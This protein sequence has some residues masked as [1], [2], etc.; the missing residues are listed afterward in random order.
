[1][2]FR[3]NLTL[4][5]TKMAGDM[6]LNRIAVHE[7]SR[8]KNQPLLVRL[9]SLDFCIIPDESGQFLVILPDD[10]SDKF[11]EIVDIDEYKIRT[12]EDIFDRLDYFDYKN[13]SITYSTFTYRFGE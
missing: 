10:L 7:H 2:L 5:D 13:F 3:E 12:V 1:M 4:K 11:I 6:P 8:D 9:D